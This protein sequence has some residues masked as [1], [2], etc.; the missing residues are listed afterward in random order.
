MPSD[1]TL[2]RSTRYSICGMRGSKPLNTKP[3]SGRLRAAAS[4]SCSTSFKR[5]VSAPVRF[6]S[7][8][9]K[10][11][12]VLKPRIGGGLST[13]TLASLISPLR[14]RVSVR[15]MP[16]TD[17][18]GRLA[19]VPGL[20]AD[21]RGAVVGDG[22]AGQQVESAD[23]DHAVHARHLARDARELRHG[24]VGAL[25]RRRRRQARH[26]DHEALVLRR[27]EAGGPRGDQS[28]DRHEQHAEGQHHE[29]R[30]AHHRR[31]RAEIAVARAL[32]GAVELGEEP[33]ERPAGAGARRRPA[34]AAARTWP[35]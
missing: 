6:C 8:K 15:T 24:G 28:P 18:A 17:S 9:V 23:E 1:L 5:A 20:E 26:R 31:H 7:T 27:H 3:I 11:P 33:A 22:L 12:L 32:E 34:A 30:V 35:A 19:L 25:E 29:D 21:E 14:R 4:S 16:P 10:P 2:S 13:S